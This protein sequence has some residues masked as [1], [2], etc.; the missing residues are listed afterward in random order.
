MHMY[1]RAWHFSSSS[2]LVLIAGD[3]WCC[4]GE[5]ETALQ[6]A[7]KESWSET[8]SS[9]DR[10]D[11]EGRKNK[12]NDG[13]GY[14]MEGRGEER[15]DNETSKIVKGEKMPVRPSDNK[16]NSRSGYRW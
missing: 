9:G 12:D 5:L 2:L 11:E 16:S 15:A 13:M 6:R 4:S 14:S 10:K 1:T 7:E 8:L 3:F